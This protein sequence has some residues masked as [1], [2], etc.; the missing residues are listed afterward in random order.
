MTDPLTCA[1][2][3]ELLTDLLESA[4]DD[5][6]RRRIV[7]HFGGCQGC[8]DYR[9]QFQQMIDAMGTLPP[10]PADVLDPVVQHELLAAYRGR[11]RAR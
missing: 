8:E 4:L 2:L 6:A 1:E 11:P 7:E 10:E 3:V 5:A 9:R